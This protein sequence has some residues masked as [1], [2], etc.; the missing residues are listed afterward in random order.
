MGDSSLFELFQYRAP[1]PDPVTWSGVAYTASSYV[2]FFV[3]DD[4]YSGF[5]L[6]RISRGG[7]R[8]FATNAPVEWKERMTT[9]L[10]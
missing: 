10:S 3:S 2:M 4:N 1:L 7:G 9:R 8:F 5:L 6:Y